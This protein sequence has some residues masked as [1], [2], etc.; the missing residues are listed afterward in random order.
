MRGIRNRVL[1]LFAGLALILGV[2]MVVTF[3]AE[4][5]SS[6]IPIDEKHF[7]DPVFRDYI[8]RKIDD[9]MD[10]KLSVKERN[11]VK[12]IWID[13]SSILTK[14]DPSLK[15][16]KGIEYF[17][18]L[19]VLDCVGQELTKLDLR[20]NTKLTSLYCSYNYLT[21]LAVGKCKDLKVV[22]CEHNKIKTMNL[23]NCKNL[24]YLE[25][26]NNQLTS[27]NVSGCTSLKELYCSANKLKKLDVSDLVSLKRFG[28][29]DNRIKEIDIS[30]SPDL[31]YLSSYTNPIKSL[32]IMNNPY[33][34]KAF[35][36][37]SQTQKYD[38][39]SSK[40]NEYDYYSFSV[41]KGTKI[42]TSGWYKSK[43]KWHYSK[44]GK[45]LT[46]WKEIGGKTYFFKKNGV[47]AANEYCKGY[48]LNK[49]GVWSDPA[50][51]SW[52]KTKKGWIYKGSN[53]K[54]LKGKTVVIDGKK[55]SFDAK[56]YKKKK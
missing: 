39:Y 54:T 23:K 45:D 19:R 9:N 28:F 47:M 10:G 2:C 36:H 31:E 15:S 4:A 6:A 25:C 32:A 51:Y 35:E 43:N 18:N 34:I 26:H 49:N 38:L 24:T 17:P 40:K 20:K 55:Y 53:G 11:R 16:L 56:G 33:L 41:P 29:D 42:K 44:D 22:Q 14:V 13:N 8:E 21:V 30:R 3:P 37:Y 48:W 7:P 50:K 12:Q 5:A 46:G 27:L 1:M 52:K